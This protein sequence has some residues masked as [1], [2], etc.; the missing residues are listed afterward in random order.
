M[1]AILSLASCILLGNLAHLQRPYV[2]MM[3]VQFLP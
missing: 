1:R 3:R 2:F